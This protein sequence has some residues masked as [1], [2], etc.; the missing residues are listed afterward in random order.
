[1]SQKTL[2]SVALGSPHAST[3]NVFG[4]GHR[5]H[6]ALLDPG[7][8]VDGRPVEGHPVVQRALELGRAD[9]EAL[10]A[11][12][13]VGEPEPD[14]P[15]APLLHHAQHVRLLLF[16]HARHVLSLVEEIPNVLRGP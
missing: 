13:D 7:E 12:H 14:E 2:A 5:Q 6:V 4:V 11:A 16:Q 9:G 1:M 10:Q 15:N 8:P 3:S